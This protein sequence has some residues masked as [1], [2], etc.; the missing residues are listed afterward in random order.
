MIETNEIL[1]ALGTDEATTLMAELTKLFLQKEYP[2]ELHN[3]NAQKLVLAIIIKELSE[4]TIPDGMDC[5]TFVCK[6]LRRSIAELKESSPTPS[7]STSS[8]TS[9]SSSYTPRS[10]SYTSYPKRS[11]KQIFYGACI[12]LGAIGSIVTSKEI[13]IGIGIAFA[14]VS[15]IGL[16]VFI[17]GVRKKIR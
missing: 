9:D 1:A 5:N 11:P 2:N 12:F 3:E 10:S 4:A 13:N 16:L 8:Y 15:V 7:E 14:A 17:N 6:Y